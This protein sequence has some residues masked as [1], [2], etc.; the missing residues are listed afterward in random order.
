MTSVNKQLGRLLIAFTA[1][2][3]CLGCTDKRQPALAATH[4]LPVRINTSLPLQSIVPVADVKFQ[5]MD[6]EVLAMKADAGSL[7]VS[8][9]P[10]GA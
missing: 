6:T 1:L 3:L 7:F 8:A 5:N 10:P 9:R 2:G 4:K